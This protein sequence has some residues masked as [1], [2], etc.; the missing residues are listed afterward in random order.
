MEFNATFI[1]SAISFIIFAILMNSIF[2][3]PIQKVVNDRQTYLDE[4]NEQAKLH[5]KKAE[6][7]MRDKAQKLEKTKLDAKKI[8]TGKADE[9]KTKKSNLAAEAQHKAGQKIES[10]KKDLH[11]A[12]GEA[13]E[14]LANDVVNLAQ[15]IASKILGSS[16]TIECVD[17]NLISEVMKISND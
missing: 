16:S 4:T 10:A 7:I 15:D 6:A 9:V 3:K 2:Y 13:Q 1:V 5:V 17:K 14:A 12:K 11:K 8:I